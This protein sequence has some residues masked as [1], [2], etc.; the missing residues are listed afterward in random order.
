MWSFLN[1]PFPAAGFCAR[2][3]RNYA[4]VGLF[5]ALF[6]IVFQ[7]F[8]INLWLTPHKTAKLIGFGLVSFVV[9]LIYSA[10]I[11]VLFP[12]M[13]A[14]EAWTVGREILSIILV[15][16]LIAAGNL[17]YS[18]VLGIA[19]LSWNGFFN[20]LLP[21][22]LL[23]VFPVTF[24]VMARQKQLQSRHQAKAVEVNDR[25]GARGAAAGA[26]DEELVL[27]AENGKDHLRLPAADLLYIESADN[28]SNI[29]FLRQGVVCRHLLRSSLWRLE[30]QLQPD[31]IL[32]C[33]RT[34]IV[35]LRQVQSTEGNA[36]GYRLK[37]SGL[38][39]VLP[40]SRSYGPQVMTRLRTLG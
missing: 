11:T 38:D 13:I 32:R 6:L 25:I 35:N 20:A 12:N 14:S 3:F 22:L 19:R 31:F 26:S 9:P 28:Y 8:D 36:A 17:Y 37:I 24:L 10:A 7:P 18:H 34:Y 30:T 4:L 16:L 29:V 15:M 40:V 21:V 2:S 1:T 5:V 33:H 27:Q 39:T 23:G